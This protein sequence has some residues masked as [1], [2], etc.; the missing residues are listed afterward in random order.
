MILTV[1]LVLSVALMKVTAS[2]VSYDRQYI[3]SGG[4]FFDKTSSFV[5]ENYFSIFFQSVII[6]IK[7][8]YLVRM[9]NIASTN[10]V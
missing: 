3:E 7:M 2:Q 9:V 4:I 6:G 1:N 10:I 5:K 8:V